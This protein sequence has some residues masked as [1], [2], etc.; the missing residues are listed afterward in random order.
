MAKIRVYELAKKLDIQSKDIIGYLAENGMEVKSQSGLDDAQT[1]MITKKFGKQEPAQ[2][3]AAPEKASAEKAASAKTA[4]HAAPG[5][6]ESEA[7]KKAAN[8]EAKKEAPAASDGKGKEKRPAAG[9]GRERPR[10]KPNISA[11]F[12][13]QYSRQPRSRRPEGERRNARPGDRGARPGGNRS[14]RPGDRSV[15]SQEVRRPLIRPLAHKDGERPSDRFSVRRSPRARSRRPGRM[16]LP[17]VR[18]SRGRRSQKTENF[19]QTRQ[20]AVCSSR[21]RMSTS[22]VVLRREASRRP[23]ER[24]YMQTGMTGDPARR[25]TG[26]PESRVRERAGILPAVRDVRQLGRMFT[27]IP[28]IIRRE[29]PVPAETAIS[30][31]TTGREPLRFRRKRS[32]AR[33]AESATITAERSMTGTFW[34]PR[35][36]SGM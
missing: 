30:A 17:S 35:S 32:G 34:D 10:K 5:N 25:I 3:K 12:N 21:G 16:Y 26:M 28:E 31:R 24:M 11:V 27:P 22:T 29:A 13:A 18:S 9:D 6:P 33:R 14:G 1:A 15:R 7:K 20:T 36:R 2:G 23:G 19:K 4:E 8:A